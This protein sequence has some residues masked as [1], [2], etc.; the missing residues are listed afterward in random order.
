MNKHKIFN[1]FLTSHTNR[2]KMV[3]R[4]GRFPTQTYPENVLEH[5]F[6]SA[7]LAEIMISIEEKN[8]NHDFNKYLVLSCAINHDL[9]EGTIGDIAAPI[10]QD[11]EL[12]EKLEEI[13]K[14]EFLENIKD[15]PDEVI[16]HFEKSYNIQLEKNTFESKLF[17]A[18]E[19]LGYVEHA[20]AEYA[21][22]NHEFKMVMQR[23]HPAILELMNE[24]IS[25]K[26]IYQKYFL[27]DIEN[28]LN[29]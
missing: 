28:I 17:N 15:L 3:K 13:E 1:D 25:L 16:K 10:K 14:K 12:K 6:K 22:G 5:T 11:E 19:R 21:V 27:K 7:L 8:G 18:I 23:Q 26:I 24:V 4:W 2:L 9:G 20:I 29:E